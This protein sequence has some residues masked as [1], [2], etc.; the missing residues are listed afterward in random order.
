MRGEARKVVETFEREWPGVLR[1][2][3]MP[4]DGGCKAALIELIQSALHSQV[5]PG[6]WTDKKPTVAGVYW[7]RWSDGTEL[8]IIRVEQSPTDPSWFI[9]H[10]GDSIMY[11]VPE[12]NDR[13]DHGE[14]YGPLTPP[15]GHAHE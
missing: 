1:N 5:S 15:E 14:F 13:G 9:Q 12:E 7:H 11:S 10:F 4:A 8:S 2:N 6:E 3:Q